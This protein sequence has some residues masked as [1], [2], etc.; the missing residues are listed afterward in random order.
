MTEPRWLS[1]EEVEKVHDVLL[2][3]GGGLRGLRDAPMLESALARP[4]NLHAYENPSIFDLAASYAEIGRHQ[5]FIEGNKRTG[6]GAANLF[7]VL[8][9]YQLQRAEYH[10]HADMM[11]QL[12]T[13]EI[14]REE[15]GKY[16]AEHSREIERDNMPE[17]RSRE[18]GTKDWFERELQ[19]ERSKTVEHKDREDDRDR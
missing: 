19:E 13:G 1:R 3:I 11:V 14:S 18:I 12:G 4:K 5:S 8:N 9:G 7:L 10:E 17:D 16:L 15:M 2:E 6:F